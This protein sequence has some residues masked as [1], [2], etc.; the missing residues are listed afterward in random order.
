[1][2]TDKQNPIIIISGPAGVGKTTV[3]KALQRDYPNLETSVTY[4]TR[5]PRAEAPEDKKIYYITIPEF[6]D[7]ITQGEFLEWA[8]VHG[9]YYGTHK[10]KTLEKLKTHPVIFNID[11]QGAKQVMENTAGHPL[12]SIFLVPESIDQIKERIIKRGHSDPSDLALR[13]ESAEKEL[14]EQGIY[15][16][17]IINSEGRLKETIAQ[18]E[19]I[20]APYLIKKTSILSQISSFFNF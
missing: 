18:V 15:Q 8:K 12:I 9:Q 17:Q 11:I 6:E 3:A 13:L 16:Y 14:K 10:N 4:T 2:D 1:M 19:K 20:L 5:Q 7:M